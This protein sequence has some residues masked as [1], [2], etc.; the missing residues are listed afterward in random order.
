[1]PQIGE[2]DDFE[3]QYMA[4][5][6]AI[7]AAHGLRIS[8][9]TDRAALDRGIHLYEPRTPSQD[10]G[11]QVSQTRI[12]LQAKGRHQSTL[13]LDKFNN[14]IQIPIKVSS[15]HLL[16]WY[17]SPEP[18]YL[19]VYIES[20]DIF[21]AED[22]REIADRQWSRG[23]GDVTVFQAA[24]GQPNMTLQ[25]RSDARLDAQRIETMLRHRSIR[26][27]GPSFRGRP[28]GHHLDPLR[29][30]L[31]PPP[32]TEHR[33][34]INRILEAHKFKSTETPLDF[35]EN[36]HISH[37]TLNHTIEWHW[38]LGTQIGVSSESSFRRESSIESLQGNCAI[39]I[40][41]DTSRR[42]S[43]ETLAVA[44]NEIIARTTNPILIFSNS[45]ELYAPGPWL[46]A[47]RTT[48]AASRLKVIG[49]GSLSYILLVATLIYIEFSPRLSWKHASYLH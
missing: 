13:P 35:D 9:A 43:V 19:V 40:E 27:D 32:A 25:I 42:A 22:V 10:N 39:I 29:S 14:S 2:H 28:L 46:A 12:W 45:E 47:A 30:E 33:D 24:K 15:D 20:A 21:L 3:Q 49:L 38:P 37:G 44:L 11:R 8:Y 4:K 26:I 34:I 5:L 23:F 36:L 6:D 1:M 31:E 41:S 16:F 17:A 7:W 48:G 18:V